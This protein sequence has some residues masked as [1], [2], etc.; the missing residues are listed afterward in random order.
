VGLGIVL[1]PRESEARPA[2]ALP[3]AAE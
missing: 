3:M 2:A 1:R